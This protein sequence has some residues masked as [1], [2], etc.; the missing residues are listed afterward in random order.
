M[1]TRRDFLRRAA[2]A[3]GAMALSPFRAGSAQE[4]KKSGLID[5]TIARWT[6][7][8]A[9]EPEQI[10][11]L[12]ERLTEK[13]INALGGMNR[14]VSTGDVVWIKPNI[15]WN[16][17]PEQAADTNP[18]VVATLI[19]LCYNAGAKK[20]KVG[21]NPCNPAKLAYAN[22]GIEAAA[23]AM[24]AEVVVLDA[25]R[26]REM[27]IGGERLKQWPVYPEI[28]ESD[29]VINVPVVKHHNLLKAPFTACMKN[30]MGVAGGER[31]KWHADIPP[32]LCDITAFMKP[33]LCVLDAVRILTGNGPSGGSLA[34]V[35]RMDTVA[36]GTDIVALDALAGELLGLDP[37][38]LPTVREGHERGLGE[39]NY[40]KLALDEL[41][42]A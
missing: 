12:A 35:K 1:H 10:K 7:E 30:Y 3:G 23:K 40:R 41:S 13:A 16:R 9:S 11:A 18:D 34:D 37:K 33:R 21:D 25:N 6:G 17:R 14:F 29:L 19:R 28:V 39:M 27:S 22:S 31:G 36:A 15:G 8:E 5:M 32:C 26:F 2:L 20:V 24:D 42:V 4:T 38:T